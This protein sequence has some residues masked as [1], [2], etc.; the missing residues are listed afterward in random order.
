MIK[1]AFILEP[2][3]FDEIYGA[4]CLAAVS[5]HAHVVGPV[6]STGAALAGPTPE[7]LREVEVLFTGWGSPLLDE[8][9]LARMPR[10]RAVFYGAGSLRSIVTDACWKRGIIFSSAAALNA[11]PVVEYTLGAILLSFKRVW[12]HARLVREKRGYE[13]LRALSIPTGWNTTIGLLSL[14]LIGRGV[15]ERLRTFNVRVLAHDPLLASEQFSEVGAESASLDELFERSD[16]VSLHAPLL[17]DTVGIIDRR[18]LD[19]LKPS[20]T[21]IN[22]ARGGLVRES[23]L[24]DFLRQRPDVQAILDVTDPEPPAPDSLLYE[25][26]NVFLTPHIAG[27]I[28]VECRRMGRA[29]VDEFHRYARRE[30]LAYAV[31]REQLARMA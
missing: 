18:R 5:A 11:V 25:L 19:L 23:D 2:G 15:A 4:E 10:L 26:P 30:A 17:P 8:S 22:T 31:T 7:W 27:S 1:A 13:P 28:G 24:T 21:F 12:H 20:A 16:V 14:G 29:M 3:H 6:P 9:L